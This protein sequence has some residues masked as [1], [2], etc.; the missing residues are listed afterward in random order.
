MLTLRKTLFTVL[1]LVF[2]SLSANLM[3]QQSDYEIV[4]EFR[5][6]Y[7]DLNNKIETAVEPNELETLNRDLNAFESRFS[8]HSLLINGAIF[9]ETFNDLMN[10]LRSS[11]DNALA[12]A[13]VIEQLNERIDQMVDEMGVFRNRVNSLNQEIVS[14][15]EQIDRSEAN[16]AQQ[17]A[18]IRQ[19]RQNLQQ[20]D[21]FVSE[22][23]EELIAKYR[24]M[25]SSVRAEYGDASERLQDNPVD[26]LKT[27]LR[28]YIE[29]ANRST[30]LELPD[31]VGMRAQHGYFSSVWD[32][33]GTQLT[34][35]FNPA[36][37]NAEI[38]EV[39]DLLAAWLNSIDGQ[40]WESLNDAFVQNGIE[41]APF[42]SSSEFNDALNS[43]VDTAYESSLESNRELDYQRFQEFSEFWNNTVKASWGELLTAGNILTHTEIAAIDVKLSSWGEA[44]S[45]TSNLMFILLIVSIAVIVGLVVLLVTKKS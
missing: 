42:T 6:A 16:E 25:D 3:A 15:E 32:R 30:N 34:E 41:L 18:L 19:Y 8:E 43:Y 40:L 33:I 11:Y 45:P 37:A 7:S 26:I 5:A 28:E 24:N 2:F 10:H 21:A 39:D 12:N 14:L 36:N 23:L 22:F 4:Q 13:T 20:R 29:I 31:Y 27:I 38:Q 9:P 17:A 44:A 1:T 35:T